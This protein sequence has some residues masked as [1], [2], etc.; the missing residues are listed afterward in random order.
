MDVTEHT[1]ARGPAARRGLSLVEAAVVLAVLAI[2]AALAIP[3][4]GAMASRSRLAAEVNALAG[5]LALARSQ[6]ARHNRVVVICR[7]EDAATCAETGDGWPAWVVFADTDGDR[8]LGPGETPLH[9]HR[10]GP[11][12]HLGYRGFPRSRYLAFQPTGFSHRNGTFTLCTSGP[13]PE[14]R[15]VIVNWAGRVRLARTGPGGRPLRCPPPP[16]AG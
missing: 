1:T 2:T 5:A 3:A 11:H 7:S 10:V 15:A 4:L 13:D 8:R 16:P 14:R 9:A 12:V 6:A